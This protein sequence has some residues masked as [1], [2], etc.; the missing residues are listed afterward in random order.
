MREVLES[1]PGCFLRQLPVTYKSF[2]G[3]NLRVPPE[4][5]T[6]HAPKCNWCP[7]KMTGEENRGNERIFK[8][9]LLFQRLHDF[10]YPDDGPLF[11]SK[12]GSIQRMRG[13][14]PA[15]QG[16]LAPRCNETPANERLSLAIAGNQNATKHHVPLSSPIPDQSVVGGRST[17]LQRGMSPTL[18]SRHHGTS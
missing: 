8:S 16:K 9:P 17:C 1:R 4:Q 14:P 18:T 6:R 15:V 7:Q 5:T 10:S 3:H 13:S 11:C 2:A 12:P